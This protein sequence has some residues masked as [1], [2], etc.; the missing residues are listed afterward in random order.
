VIATQRAAA[1]RIDRQLYG[2]SGRQGDPG[3]FETIVS[4][5]DEPVAQYWSRPVLRLAALLAAGGGPLSR[6][7]ARALTL[8]PQSSEE[9]R[10][11]R[12]R[13]GLVEVEEYLDDILAF[14]GPRE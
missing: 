7:V 12:I 6:M 14:S 8:L 10:G 9:S 3:S 4:L 2:R 13:R 5:E 11:A 1:G